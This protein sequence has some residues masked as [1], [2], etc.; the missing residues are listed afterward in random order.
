M[1][2]L[3]FDV[4]RIAIQVEVCVVMEDK[5]LEERIR[6]RDT[7]ALEEAIDAYGLALKALVTRILSGRGSAEDAEEC[8]SDA[9]LAAWHD[10]DKYDGQ[11]GSFRT[12]LYTIAKYKALDKRRQISRLANAA[13]LQEDTYIAGA[14]AEQQAMSSETERELIDLIRKFGEPDRSLFWQRYFYYEELEHLAQLFG[15]TKKAVENRLYRC[16]VALRQALHMT[17]KG[18]GVNEE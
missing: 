15:L 2:A 13:S 6:K 3:A 17:E 4:L 16:R 10:I 9:F 11:R 7:R 8:V 12:W 1:I 14:S 18:D 5:G